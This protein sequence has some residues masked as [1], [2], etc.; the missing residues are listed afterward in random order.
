[1]SDASAAPE[2]IPLLLGPLAGE[3]E[4]LLLV[5]APDGAGNVQVRSWSAAAWG[6]GPR[7]H[8]ERAIEMLDR[9]E[10]EVRAGRTMNQS[11]HA[12]RRWLRGDA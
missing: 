3:P 12:L 4:T 6:S 10:R 8:T 7:A 9:I 5:S 2:E 11:L 1:M